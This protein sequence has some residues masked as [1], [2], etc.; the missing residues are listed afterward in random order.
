MDARVPRWVTDGVGELDVPSV[1]LESLLDPR[2]STAQVLA[3]PDLTYGQRGA[4]ILTRIEWARSVD[5]FGQVLVSV[6]PVLLLLALEV[7]PSF[8]LSGYAAVLEQ[9]VAVVFPDGL[10][11]NEAEEEA[12]WDRF[13]WSGTRFVF[14]DAFASVDGRARDG[15]VLRAITRYVRTHPSDFFDEPVSPEAEVRMRL[16]YAQGLTSRSPRRV[17]FARAEVLLDGA[18]ERSE[19]I[20]DRSLA[21]QCRQ[22]LVAL[23]R[24]RRTTA[25]ARHLSPVSRRSHVRK[26]WH[27]PRLG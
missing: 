4:Y 26:T 17:D 11:S 5:G 8:G 15:E 3:E 13:E 7:A 24:L 1:V 20:D 27:P 12:A 6:E 10:P 18:L 16:G 25:A 19:A 21:E 9:A 14:G 2:L 22:A 23:E